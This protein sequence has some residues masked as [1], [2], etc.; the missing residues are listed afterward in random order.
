MKESI[1]IVDDDN[2]TCISIAKALS[3]EYST[4]T[5]SNGREALDILQ[6]QN[7]IHVVLTDIKMPNIN[8]IELLERIRF[9]D[10]T[11]IVIMITSYSDPESLTRAR[12]CGAYDYITKPVDLERLESTIR[13]ALSY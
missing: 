1:L 6:K 12:H 10:D 5:A 4:Y 3:G 7:D 11:I 8:G 13:K 9:Q 2:N